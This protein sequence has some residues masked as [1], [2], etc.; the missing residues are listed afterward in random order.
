MINFRRI[1][2]TAKIFAKE[3]TNYIIA[4]KILIFAIVFFFLTTSIEISSNIQAFQFIAE[5]KL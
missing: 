2:W 3:Y 1:K 5:S 4:P